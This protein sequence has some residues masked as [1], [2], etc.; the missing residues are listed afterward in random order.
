[1]TYSGDWQDDRQEGFGIESWGKGEY[2][3]GQWSNG[4]K[5]GYG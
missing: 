2:Y 3:K 5:N 4:H 1:M